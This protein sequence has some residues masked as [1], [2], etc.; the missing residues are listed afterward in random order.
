MQAKK[1]PG[2]SIPAI[3]R[4]GRGEGA[5]VP[6]RQGIRA[7]GQKRELRKLD[8]YERSQLYD[9]P[10]PKE[11]DPNAEQIPHREP[12]PEELNRDPTMEEILERAEEPQG[13]FEKGEARRLGVAEELAEIREYV[14]ELRG[15]GYGEVYHRSAV[16]PRFRTSREYLAVTA[17]RDFLA[18]DRVNK[19]VLVGE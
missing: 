2:L 12:T 1:D 9:K 5:P 10:L 18:F 19:R 6:R 11:R 14:V 15:K 3:A 4:R 17:F 7:R 16:Q 8:D 13:T